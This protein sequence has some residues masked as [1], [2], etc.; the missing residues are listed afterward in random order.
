MKYQ[1]KPTNL[2]GISFQSQHEAAR[3]A[4][5]LLLQKCRKIRNLQ[6]QVTFRL[7]LPNP[8]APNDQARN[9]DIAKYI[10][11]FVYEEDRGGGIW[12]QVVEDAKSEATKTDVYR[13]KKRLM[14]AIHGIEIKEV[15][16]TSRWSKDAVK[17]AQKPKRKIPSR[18]LPKGR[19]LR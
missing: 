13:I 2:D 3:W 16:N 1:N 18:K 10:A 8:K 17:A 7:D 12:V 15:F 4:E 19:S 14:L 5:L 11:D 6:R 9:I